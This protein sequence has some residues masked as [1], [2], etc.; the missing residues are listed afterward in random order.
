MTLYTPNERE[1]ELLASLAWSADHATY[2]RP[3]QTPLDLGGTNGSHHSG[4]L[5]KL[6][7]KGLVNYKQ[8]TGSEPPKWENAK[9]LPRGHRGSK[10]YRI[11]PLG[12]EAL[13]RARESTDGE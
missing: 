6:A 3:W 2:P 9:P 13:E 7:R 8:R 1:R 10:A 4:T 5:A 11:T 12:R